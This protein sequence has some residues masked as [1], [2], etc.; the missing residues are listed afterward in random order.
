M[1]GKLGQVPEWPNNAAWTIVLADGATAGIDTALMNALAVGL[2][3]RGIR[4]A[5]FELP[6]LCL[7]TGGNTDRFRV[8]HLQTIK[9][10]TLAIARSAA[11]IRYEMDSQSFK[12]SRTPPNVRSGS[13]LKSQ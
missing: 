2:A 5:R 6:G 4:V 13:M 1:Q 10:P 9:R 3:G 7:S 8:E 12:P 11:T